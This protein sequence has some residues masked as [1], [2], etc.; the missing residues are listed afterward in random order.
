MKRFRGC[1]AQN[2]FSIDK[3]KCFVYI[4]VYVNSVYFWLQRLKRKQDLY[5]LVFCN[6]C[7]LLIK[8]VY[9]IMNCMYFFVL[10]LYLNFFYRLGFY[11]LEVVNLVEGQYVKIG[12]FD[13]FM[14]LFY[15]LK[16][17]KYK[18]FYREK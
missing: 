7:F 4:Y 9:F 6:Y 8:I 10:K 14:Y 11:F 17:S 18:V 1:F 15:G 2:N 5:F 3:K 16:Y 12:L 13:F